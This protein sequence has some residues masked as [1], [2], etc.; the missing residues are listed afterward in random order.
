MLK[1]TKFKNRAEREGHASC[2]P[3]QQTLNGLAWDVSSNIVLHDS[4]ALVTNT[5]VEEV[6][7]RV[8]VFM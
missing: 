8:V 2:Q 7:V 1:E 5:K 6:Q 4:V 3:A